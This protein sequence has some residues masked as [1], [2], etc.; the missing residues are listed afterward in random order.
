MIRVAMHDRGRVHE[1]VRLR[2]ER[3]EAGRRDWSG[4]RRIVSKAGYLV[5]G[6]AAVLLLTSGFGGSAAAGWKKRAPMPVQRSEVAAAV[7]NG[8]IAVVGGFYVDGSSSKEV[9]L[10][11]P[12]TNR[13][14][15]LPD[16]PVGVNHA[17]A[18]AAGGKLYVVGG[19]A[20]PPRHWLR[21]AY[22]YYG[23][24]WHDLAPMPAARAAGG[25]AIVGRK[26]YVVGGV[27]PKGLARRAFVFDLAKGLV[28]DDS[29]PGEAGASGRDRDRRSRLRARGQARRLRREPRHLR[30]VLARDGRLGT[31]CRPSRS[32]EEAPA[33][34][35]RA[36]IVVSVGGEAPEGTI[37]SVYG[38]ELATG[39]WRR[40]PDLPT[41]RHGLAVASGQGHRLRDRRRHEPGALHERRQRGA[42]ALGRGR[43]QS[44]S[45][46]PSSRAR[47]RRPARHRASG[48]RA[49]RA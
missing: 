36:D 26:L 49:P 12:S 24:R 17:M 43:L 20:D 6:L 41:A 18:A 22:A 34:R 27:A 9:D 8:G 44:P 15:R 21:Y 32:R 5:G 47:R 35:S 45:L 39:R 30:G 7:Y 46:S 33:R 11:Q 37:H 14:R 4:E 42:D 23:N 38:Y 16:L 28:V 2:R 10:Y 13:W 31:A 19:Y 48:Y 40:L 25:A 1:D 3:T 29:R